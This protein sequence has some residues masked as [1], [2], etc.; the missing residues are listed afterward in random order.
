MD[1]CR[2]D[3]KEGYEYLKNDTPIYHQTDSNKQYIEYR[4]HSLMKNCYDYKR[5][6]RLKELPKGKRINF[7]YEKTRQN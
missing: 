7:F 3:Y 2:V 4:N 6:K 5:I 1:Y